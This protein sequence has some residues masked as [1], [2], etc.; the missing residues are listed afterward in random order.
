M[1]RGLTGCNGVFFYND[2]QISLYDVFDCEVKDGDNH[3]YFY[4]TQGRVVGYLPR[5]G[6]V[7]NIATGEK[8]NLFKRVKNLDN[9]VEPYNF[10]T[11]KALKCVVSANI[12]SEI[13]FSLND[14]DGLSLQRERFERMVSKRKYEIYQEWISNNCT[15]NNSRQR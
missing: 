14:Q 4:K 15:E 8:Y 12:S 5:F 9:C 6:V 1:N 3:V 11:K 7:E 2:K 10:K 13:N